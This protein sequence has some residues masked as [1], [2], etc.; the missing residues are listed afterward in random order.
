MFI[1]LGYIEL[2][3]R[4]INILWEPNDLGEHKKAD[5]SQPDIFRI[6]HIFEKEC[7]TGY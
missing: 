6:T 4:P 5:Q 1:I 7:M 3:M 2:K